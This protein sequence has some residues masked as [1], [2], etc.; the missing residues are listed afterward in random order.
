MDMQQ[1]ASAVLKS[2]LVSLAIFVVG[3]VCVCF[4]FRVP[5][6]DWFLAMMGALPGCVALIFVVISAIW[7]VA[8]RVRNSQPKTTK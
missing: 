1:V 7:F 3:F 5:R 8:Q 4:L 6:E 2:F